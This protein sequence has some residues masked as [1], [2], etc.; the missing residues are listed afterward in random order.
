MYGAERYDGS[1]L[2]ES[3]TG[4]ARARV[5]SSLKGDEN[6]ALETYPPRVA[7]NLYANRY[8]AIAKKT[9]PKART[10]H[11]LDESTCEFG[12]HSS[13]E[14]LVSKGRARRIWSFYEFA[15]LSIV[16]CEKGETGEIVRETSR[17]TLSLSLVSLSL[18]LSR[19]KRANAVWLGGRSG[20]AGG[21]TRPLVSARK[22]RREFSLV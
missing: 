15:R 11:S 16:F 9:R 6:R 19:T 1:A 8:R 4:D 20:A 10:V 12:H 14:S 22:L 18:S 13:L 3:R 7:E 2:L 17:D 5:G 21:S